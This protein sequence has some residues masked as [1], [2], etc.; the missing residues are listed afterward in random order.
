MYIYIYICVCVHVIL[1][2]LLYL[3]KR[4]ASLD[5]PSDAILNDLLL[6]ILFTKHYYM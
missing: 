4:K 3:Y 2:H 1:R 6:Y 5:T